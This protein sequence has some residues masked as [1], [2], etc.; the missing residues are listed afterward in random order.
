M[1]AAVD[2][3]TT[4]AAPETYLGLDMGST[5]KSTD[6]VAETVPLWLPAYLDSFE[7]YVDQES[8]SSHWQ[9]LCT[10]HVHV[11]AQSMRIYI[12]IYVCHVHK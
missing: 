1:K 3:A 9:V 8:T 10:P 4:D 2:G 7:T 11:N 5:P 12:Y 6:P